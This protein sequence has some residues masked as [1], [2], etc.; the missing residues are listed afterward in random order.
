MQPWRAR[1]R[2]APGVIHT[3]PSRSACQLPTPAGAATP[4]RPGRGQGP[5]QPDLPLARRPRGA[6]IFAAPI[7]ADR[8]R[9]A[10]MTMPPRPRPAVQD[11]QA[12]RPAVAGD[13][14]WRHLHRP[15]DPRPAATG[16][17]SSGRRAPRRTTR[18]AARWTARGRCWRRPASRRGGSAGSSHA[19]TLFTNALIERK[20]ART[21][22]LTTAGFARRAGDRAGAE[23][24]ALRPL[25]RDAEAA[26]TAALAAGGA[27]TPRRRTARWKS[28]S[29]STA[30]WA[31]WRRW[32]RRGSRASPWS[33][34]MPMP[35]RRMN[36]GARRRWRG[37]SRALGLLSSE[38]APRDPRIPTR[39]HHR[40]QCLCP[41]VGR[42][43]PGHGW[44]RR[45]ARRA[46]PA[47]CS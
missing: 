14:Y 35:T 26:G 43:L 23:I 21:G 27:G 41:A 33:S 24:R 7:V 34:C 13:R 9:R 18:P 15:G 5:G 12:G 39:Q 45:C 44:R 36:G 22:L 32:S 8:L 16:A 2:Q 29:T 25:H 46:S 37:A 19:T 30:P 42:D 3:T 31:R 17:R 6:A 47:G 10:S 40:R 20:G 4:A 11:T 1:N 38:I 28:R